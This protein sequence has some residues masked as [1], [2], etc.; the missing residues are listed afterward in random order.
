[1]HRPVPTVLN[2]TLAAL[3]D[4]F[5]L[6]PVLAAVL[7]LGIAHVLARRGMAMRMAGI[8][9]AAPWPRWP[10]WRCRT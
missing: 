9:A 2:G 6:E 3:R 7:A 10:G 4:V 8:P 1:M 5:K